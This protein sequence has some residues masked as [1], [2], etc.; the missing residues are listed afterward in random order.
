MLVI[1]FLRVGKR[2]QPFF[3]IV[4]TEKKRG[5][6]SGR[7]IEKLGFY[8]P[9]KGEGKL[10]AERIK[11]WLSVGA[12]PSDTVWNL[13]VSEK[14]VKGKK[15]PVHAKGTSKAQEQPPKE[16]GQKESVP[17]TT[18]KEQQSGE[19]PEGKIEAKE[20]ETKQQEAQPTT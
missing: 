4:V 6:K 11:Y 19:K 8:N 5:P 7:S 15:I 10:H 2:N 13:L 12:K 17:A 18:E 3:A 9:L 14:I 1:R 16:G 20:P